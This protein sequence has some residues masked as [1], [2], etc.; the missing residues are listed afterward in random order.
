MKTLAL[1]LITS[2]CFA[3]EPGLTVRSGGISKTFSFKELSKKKL[4]K[5]AVDDD[6]AYPGKKM[7]YWGFP[8]ADLFEG[9]KVADDNVIVFQCLDGF[10]APMNKERL[11]NRSDKAS[12]AYIAIERAVDKWPQVK[13]DKPGTAGPYYLVWVDPKKSNVGPEEW[14]YQLAGF[15]VK[16]SLE[17][18]FPLIAPSRSASGSVME[19][20]K[21][22]TK[23]CFACHTLNGQ[24][25]SNLGPDLNI[26]SNPVEYFEPN[27]LRKLI[28]NPQLVRKWPKGIMIGFTPQQL[29]DPDIEKIV[30][31]LGHMA[32]NKAK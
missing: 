16:S 10:S 30:L 31:Y 22:F 25:T 3:A 24:G 26:P 12:R 21:L 6:P 14:P 13:P 15:E 20:F 7:M 1:L 2:L 23:N 27:F 5:I 8:A 18:A 19:G 32:D 28:R 17:D 4:K 29:S 11:L 9:M